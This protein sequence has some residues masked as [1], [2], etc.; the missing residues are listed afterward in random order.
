MLLNQF[1]INNLNKAAD[2]ILPKV[3]VGFLNKTVALRKQYAIERGGNYDGVPNHAVSTQIP[4]AYYADTT[5]FNQLSYT[6]RADFLKPNGLL[7]VSFS[8]IAA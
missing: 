3:P 1:S 6:L 8:P 4:A 2:I 7:E 5:N